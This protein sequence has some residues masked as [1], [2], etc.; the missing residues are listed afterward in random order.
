MVIG[1]VAGGRS[2]RAARHPRL[3]AFDNQLV[4][5]MAFMTGAPQGSI[6]LG[7]APVK[8]K[9]EAAD[10]FTTGPGCPASARS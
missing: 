10:A 3:C 6:A 4:A 5:D 7:R 9:I 2:S 1:G 8:G